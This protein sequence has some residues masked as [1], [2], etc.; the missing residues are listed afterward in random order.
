MKRFLVALLLS[1]GLA[2]AANASWVFVGS[3]DVDDGPEWF[4][5]IQPILTGREAAARCL[6]A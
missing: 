6:C 2:G 4:P 5:E 3:W 1:L